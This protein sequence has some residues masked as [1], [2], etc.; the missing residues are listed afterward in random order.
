[1]LR[2]QERN[3]FSDEGIMRHATALL[4]CTMLGHLTSFKAWWWILEHE[5]DHLIPKRSGVG[6]TLSMS[7]IKFGLSANKVLQTSEQIAHSSDYH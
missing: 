2:T 6:I 5:I 4:Q 1:M 3:S 7:Q